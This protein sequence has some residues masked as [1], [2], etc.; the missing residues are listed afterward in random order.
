LNFIAVKRHCDQG[1]SYKGKHFIGASLQ[2][3]RLVH[4]HHSGKPGSVQA[5]MVL[6]EELR[7]LEALNREISEWGGRSVS[8]GALS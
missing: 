5:N 7:R 2:F 4:Y 6:K 8:E 3:Q 1:K